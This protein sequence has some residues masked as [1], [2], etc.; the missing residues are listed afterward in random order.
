MSVVWAVA[1]A[2][3][4]GVHVAAVGVAAALAAHA[5]EVGL[6]EARA[7]H[8]GVGGSAVV[9]AAP[10]AP[11]VATV[12]AGCDYRRCSCLASCW[13]LLRAAPRC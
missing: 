10:T 8:A 2:V 6:V 11:A 7:A 9:G 4:H 1:S 12:A 13:G 3:G 5:A